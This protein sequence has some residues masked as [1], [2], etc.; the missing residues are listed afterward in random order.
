MNL[1]L[2]GIL[3][4]QIVDGFLNAKN[5]STVPFT[6]N[7]AAQHS[8]SAYLLARLPIDDIGFL[9]INFGGRFCCTNLSTT[10]S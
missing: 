6:G 9:F 1:E 10:L 3:M 4:P 8:I 2:A 5:I 7:S